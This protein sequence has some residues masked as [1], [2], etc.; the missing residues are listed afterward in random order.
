MFQKT[1]FTSRRP[2]GPPT[3]SAPTPPRP[4]SPVLLDNLVYLR[5]QFG[6]SSDLMI[7]ELN[8]GGFSAAIITIEGMVNRHALADTILLPVTQVKAGKQRDPEAFMT[9]LRDDVLASSDMIQ[10]RAM[11]EL[12]NLIAS[13]FAAIAVDGVPYMILGGVQGFAMRGVSEPSSEVMLRGSREGF[14][15]VIR[16]N[17][18]MIRRRLKTPDLTF[19]MMQ[20][21]K[22]SHTDV[23]LCYLRKRV[24]EKLLRSVRERIE[25]LPLDVVLDSGYIQPFLENRHLSIFTSVNTTERPDTLCGKISEGR[26]GILVDGTPFALIIPYLFVENFQAMDDYTMPP[27]YAS[28]LRILK[29]LAFF[30]SL[31]L[32]GLYVAVGTHHPEMFPPVLLLSYLNADH[33]TPF[34]LTFE[35]LLIHFM[36]EIMR[37]A[38]L[39]F[40][41]AAGH[42]VSIV[43]ALVIGQAAV[44]AGLVGAPMVIIVALTAI[45]SFIL[46]TLYAPISILRFVFILLG[47]ALGLYGILLGVTLLLCSICAIDVLG[48]PYTAPVSPLTFKALKDVVVRADWR[49]LWRSRFRVQNLKG[50]QLGDDKGD[51]P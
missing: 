32:P 37:E 33:T 27:Y 3:D 14:T 17:L 20:A 5:E 19:E 42:A 44:Q 9:Y 13:G 1:R 45:S 38:G 16:I 47:G 41:R 8:L 51:Q 7:R 28:F 15:E 23:C 25:N 18:S 43:G 30:I 50:S 6:V 40:P 46:P 4:I 2:A 22:T 21:G 31:L 39:R 12:I 48:L 29:Y 24:S 36:F 26:I 35:A 49:Q 11:E 10:V 34:P